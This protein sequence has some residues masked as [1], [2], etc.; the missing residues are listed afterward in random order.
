MDG[1]EVGM[2]QPVQENKG[3]SSLLQFRM[4]HKN[5]PIMSESKKSN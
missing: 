2:Q 3:A 4:S 1:I 5:K